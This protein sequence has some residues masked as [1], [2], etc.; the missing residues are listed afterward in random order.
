MSSDGPQDAFVLDVMTSRQAGMSP[1]LG[2]GR[3]MVP[4]GM[5][6]IARWTHGL[7]M[8]HDPDVQ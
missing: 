5:R 8:W 1:L 7:Q 3:D 6:S 2:C 4:F